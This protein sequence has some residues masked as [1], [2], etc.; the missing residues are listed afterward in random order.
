MLAGTLVR[1]SIEDFGL[2]PRAQIEL[3]RGATMFT[4]ETGSGKT[5]VLGALAFVLGERANVEMVR[6]GSPAARVTMEVVPAA[7]LRKRLNDDGFILDEGEN[8]VISREL[9]EGG[10][11]ALRINARPATAGYIREIAHHIA[12]IVGQHEAQRLLSPSYHLE[13]L[14]RFGGEKIIAARTEVDRRYRRLRG[15]EAELREILESEERAFAAYQFAQF[16]FDEITQAA[17]EA[18]EDTRLSE[19][20]RYLSNAER[21]ASSLRA[22]HDALTAEEIGAYETVGSALAALVPLADLHGALE[23]IA[24]ALA[25][26]QSEIN[27]IAL[28]MSREMERSEFNAGELETINERLYTIEQLKKKYGASIEQVLAS[29]QDFERTVSS[30]TSRDEHRRTLEG[31]IALQKTELG[32]AAA[33]LR[34]LRV[35]A[36]KKL[37]QRVCAELT[38]LALP[39]A[40]FSVTFTARPQIGADGDQN[41]AFVFAANAGQELRE[42]ARVAS[43]GEL[44]RVLLALVIVAGKPEGGA[45]IFDEIDAGIG[46]A[47]A[48]AVGLRLGKLASENQVVCVTHLAAIAT[49]ADRHYVLEKRERAGM[50]TIGV[51]ELS[52]PAERTAEVARMLSGDARSVALEHATALLD[53]TR[54]KRSRRSSTQRRE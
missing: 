43:G 32:T 42:L 11:S 37:E 34:R 52:Q 19:R 2:I 20:R 29:G 48:T 14:D 23:E 33:A 17:L 9:T 22:A 10:K 6:S 35:D 45:L 28:W 31:N 1:L 24:G 54:A 25:G 39:S 18:G 21:I 4:G 53:D 5:M 30:F 50:T 47:T 36:G 15:L 40:R 46:G 13:V 44:S 3:A 12:D 41:I 26:A 8:A 51:V 49:W 7:A 16:A 38:E 27:D